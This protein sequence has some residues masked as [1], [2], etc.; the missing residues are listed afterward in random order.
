M[1]DVWPSILAADMLHLEYDIK[2]ISDTISTL[3]FDVM[4]GHFVPN[5]S[6]G[7]DMLRQIKK[8]FPDINMDVHLMM[9]KPQTYLKIFCDAGASAITVHYE[10]L[11]EQTTH[12][13]QGIRKLGIKAGLSVKPN[14]SIKE[15]LPFLKECD[16]ILVMTVEPG[17]GGQKFMPECL[18]KCTSL[19]K[20]G[21]QGIISVDGGI[22]CENARLCTQNG[23]DA[24]VMGTSVFKAAD[25]VS[26]IDYCKRC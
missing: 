5:L 16:I 9:E 22:S 6:F 2:R 8:S 23:V 26:V 13:L 18:Q 10:A 11:L 19:R 14:T 7:P 4:D 21:Y 3:H 17:F 20:A 12:V 1:A 15:I 24:L 25:P